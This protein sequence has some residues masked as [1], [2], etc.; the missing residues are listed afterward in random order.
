MTL[1][2]CYNSEQQL[3][4]DTLRRSFADIETGDVRNEIVQARRIL[5]ELSVIAPIS[6][7]LTG[8]QIS[9]NTAIIVAEEAG[10]A[11]MSYPVCGALLC[12]TITNKSDFTANSIVVFACNKTEMSFV[13]V[14]PIK[15]DN[16]V[17]IGSETSFVLPL[18]HPSVR[19]SEIDEN[20]VGASWMI[21][22]K[23]DDLDQEIGE[24]C[25]QAAALTM[26]A[27]EMLGLSSGLFDKAV[28]FMS[29]REQFGQPIGRFQVL[30][31]RIA[32]EWV[33]LEEARLAVEF[34][35][36]LHSTQANEDDILHAARIAIAVTSEAARNVAEFAIQIHGAV[37]F[38]WEGGLHAALK[39]IRRLSLSSG[40]A[41][42]HFEKIGHNYLTKLETQKDT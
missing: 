40:S 13:A 18:P 39:R 33:R 34:S 26:N 22:L 17:V 32:D 14:A 19:I 42:S 30:R 7:E 36:C 8:D 31:H 24:S 25:L 37:G 21:E 3:L 11:C 38:T 16:L 2:F 10:R 1:A 27:A 4:C 9:L 6:Q 15:P 29:D 20:T 23:T 12:S 35:A 5:E 28:A 41:E